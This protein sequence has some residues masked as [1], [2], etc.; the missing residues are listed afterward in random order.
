MHCFR[1]IVCFLFL[2][3]LQMAGTA[4]L[5]QLKHT[6]FKELSGMPNRVI[7][8]IAEDGNGI[9]WAASENNLQWFDGTGFHEVPYGNGP[10]EVPGLVFN[11]LY[12]SP[13]NEIWV[14]Y[15]K[16]FSVYQ[17]FTHSFKHY[18]DIIP[19]REN[20][21]FLLIAQAKNELVLSSGQHLYYVDRSTKKI[22]RY[23]NNEAVISNTFGYN[24]S[25][26]VIYKLDSNNISI[27]QLA[28]QQK[29]EIKRPGP[30]LDFTF[31]TFSNSIALYATDHYISFFDVVSGQ[32]LKTIPYPNNKY[33]QAYRRPSNIIQKDR[34]TVL[35]LLDDE[36]WEADLLQME[37]T[38]KLT[39]L[40]GG[41]FIGNGYFKTALY[42]S[43]GN[44]WITSN[45]HGLTRIS[46]RSQPVQIIGPGNSAQNFVKCFVV[47]KAGNLILVG[48]YGKGLMIYDTLG[49]F[50]KNFPLS[51]H[52]EGALLTSIGQLDAERY[53][54]F[55]HS[56][57]QQYI[58]NSRTM[59]VSVV[60]GTHLS[61]GYYSELQEFEKGSFFY[62]GGTEL[63]KIE[64]K[65]D[66]LIFSRFTEE[67]R[68]RILTKPVIKARPT[69]FTQLTADP[70]FINCLKQLGLQQTGIQSLAQRNNNWLFGTIKGIYEFDKAGKL[71]HS[72]T[73]KS[74]LSDDY[75]YA[76]I[77]D[78]NGDLWCS[79]NKGLSRIDGK[80]HVFNL[81]KED[82]L[83]SDEFNYGAASKTAD[84][85]LFFG[86]VNGLNSF[87]PNQLSSI[88]DTPRLMI[89]HISS[90]ENILPADTA[91]W[92]VKSLKLPFENNRIKIN[93]SAIGNNMGSYYN[94]QY[95]VKG[96]DYEWKD[97]GHT[98]EI[99]LALPSGNYTVEIAVNNFF[100]Q[101][102]N[103]QKIISIE[104]VPPYYQ[105]WWFLT[106]AVLISL[107][108]LAL[109]IQ[110]INR[111]KFR[112]KL[113]YIKMQQELEAERQRISRDL[114]D[115]MGAY[116]TA[117]L[118]NVEK[119][120]IQKGENDELI[121]MKNNADNILNSLRETIWVLNNKEISVSDFS[122]A[123]KTHCVKALQNFEDIN[124]EAGE[125]IDDNKILT[126]AEAIHFDKILK[127]A[128]QNII[129]HSNATQVHFTVISNRQ[130]SFSLT[131][132]G[133]GYDTGTKKTGN[134]LENMRWRA[135]EAAAEL[136]IEST[137]GKGSI[138]TI[139]K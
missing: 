78:N 116:T 77:F 125:I 131:D 120:R 82:G 117:L 102:V 136:S 19:A 122:D 83:Q 44:L 73:T 84:G 18:K 32:L 8:C 129:K 13:E 74:G 10:H 99:N 50:I 55:I 3:L 128:F 38:K 113:A 108:M 87:Y 49:N 9:L 96:L 72:Y 58:F 69:N 75:I 36:L 12:K 137:E 65:N 70:Y 29:I 56:D 47:N 126:A 33:L 17:P 54:L 25:N 53:L 124:F 68:K 134:G 22:V 86:G 103:A 88:L 91:F 57:T 64:W 107:G 60:K 46:G 90:N 93:F 4:Q 101:E 39:T 139:R 105:R 112:K 71:L 89:T 119:L 5:Q 26:N 45:L 48:T 81:S 28:N 52:G 7:K 67:E 40:T 30:K 127:E 63:D 15:N 80:G 118:A 2:L 27:V 138:I 1:K 114:H 109:I 132:N 24:I 43:R 61:P 85:Q 35:V 133:K 37:F 123:F 100:S 95:R 34:R 16:G 20:E 79:H 23:E 94:Y 14:F 41:N 135:K 31:H 106:M 21:I 6:D 98:R 11:Q 110:T 97:L 104:I 59:S 130:L 115:N 51:T 121:K 76:I 42:D 92:N 62:F 111:N 66:R